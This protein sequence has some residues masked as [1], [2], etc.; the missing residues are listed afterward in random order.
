M[1]SPVLDRFKM[2]MFWSRDG[3]IGNDICRTI[4]DASARLSSSVQL[5]I[6]SA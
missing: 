4:A 2:Q 6:A 3:F 5:V 1:L